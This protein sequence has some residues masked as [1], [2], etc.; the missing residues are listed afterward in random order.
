MSSNACDFVLGE[1]HQF[2]SPTIENTRPQ[3]SPE[4]ALAPGRSNRIPV[5][6]LIFIV[7]LGLELRWRRLQ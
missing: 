2:Y 6:I 5:P 7:W 1:G 4:P 3:R